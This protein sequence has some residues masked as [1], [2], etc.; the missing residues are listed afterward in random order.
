M[1]SSLPWMSIISV[2][3]P[4]A[5]AASTD[6]FLMCLVFGFIAVMFALRP[7]SIRGGSGDNDT[8]RRDPGTVSFFSVLSM[9]DACQVEQK[10]KSPDDGVLLSNK[11]K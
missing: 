7:R 10:T 2:P 3:G 4:G 5:P 6:F 11:I 8:K 1:Q 9:R